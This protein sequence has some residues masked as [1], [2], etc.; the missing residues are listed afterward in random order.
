MEQGAWSREQGAWSREHGAFH[1]L[2]V[3]SDL[4][5]LVIMRHNSYRI[6][7][8]HGAWSYEFSDLAK[9]VII[10]HNSYRS[11]TSS[12]FVASSIS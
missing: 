8:E 12:S 3:F 4:E 6:S 7:M 1:S 10:R 11:L 5:K 9:P 2:L